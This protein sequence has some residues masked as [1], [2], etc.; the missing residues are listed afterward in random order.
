MF[1]FKS[2]KKKKGK[3]RT[4]EPTLTRK[5]LA[6]LKR[7]RSAAR[8]KFIQTVSICFAC[9]V[10]LGVPL[11][12]IVNV[13]MAMA[14]ALG[15]PVM[16]FSYQYPRL[17]LWFFLIYMP[18]SGTVVYWVVGGNAIF[19]L[20]KDAFYLPAALALAVECYRN[21][22]NFLYP[23][24]LKMTLGLLLFCALMTLLIVNGSMQF[25][26]D[27]CSAIADPSVG[28]NCKE[29]FPLLQ[30]LLGL[31]VLAGYVP[32]MFSAYLL[33]DT[34]KKLLW[35][36]RTHV[37]LAITCC[38]L[39]IIQYQLLRS[40]ICPSTEALGV[41]GDDL[42][43]ASLD[44]K[45]LVGGAL[46]YTPSQG[47]IRLPG[48]F[49]SPWHWA[50]F[51]NSNSALTFATA[52]SDPSFLWR[53]GG[54]LGMGVV[55]ISAVISGQRIATILVPAIIV[56]LLILTGQVANL[57]RFLPI[58]VILS[59]LL[60]VAAANN[61]ELIQE[62]LNSTVER[63][64][65]A[66][67]HKF[68]Q[69]QFQWSI[70]EQR[71]P[72]GRGLGTGTNSTR[73]FGHAVLIETFHPKLLYEMGWAGL[74]AFIIFTS[75]IAYLTF[76]H[77]R[78]VKDKSLRSFGSSFWVFI[79]ILSFFP[80]WYPLDTD[81]VCVYYWFFAGVIFR[82]PEIDKEEQKKLKAARESELQ[83]PPKRRKKAKQRVA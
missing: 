8:K 43:K 58:A 13:K 35:V 2:R 39:N 27:S 4:E 9:I 55:F 36:T 6:Q 54:M 81:P 49:V 69:E 26:W 48:T 22:K 61:P 32:L 14:V 75:H 25:L 73:M 10:L 37:I 82:L 65:H 45:C 67:P 40:G 5:E 41:T 78:K 19:Q 12:L 63:I 7:Q 80:Y 15:L 17:S 33:I 3:S 71:G 76:K 62:R 68:I 57:K 60:T 18:F 24:D 72:L 31:K 30:G 64:S 77:Y 50:W 11:S 56:T 28:K 74:L 38:V 79:F 44:A 1:K 34:K 42:F 47:Q 70:D 23:K 20:A 53:I 21:K 59:L 66:P 52:F 16:F 51:L 46:T 83:L 29:K